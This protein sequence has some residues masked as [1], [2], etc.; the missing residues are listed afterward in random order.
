MVI[1]DPR[2]GGLKRGDKEPHY[3]FARFAEDVVTALN[4]LVRPPG[5]RQQPAQ[6]PA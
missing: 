3:A 2:R 5:I 4:A 1:A 6:F